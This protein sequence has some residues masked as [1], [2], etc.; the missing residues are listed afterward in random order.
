MN[1]IKNDTKN[2]SYRET[3]KATHVD[4]DNA[5]PQSH[6]AYSNVERKTERKSYF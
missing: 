4:I 2:A 6:F 1:D 3:Q 5:K